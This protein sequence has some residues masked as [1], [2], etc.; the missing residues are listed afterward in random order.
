MLCFT[1]IYFSL[2]LGEILLVSGRLYG[3]LGFLPGALYTMMKVPLLHRGHLNGAHNDV[4]IQSRWLAGVK[5]TNDKRQEPP[6]NGVLLLGP[7]SSSIGPILPLYKWPTRSHCYSPLL[8]SVMTMTRLYVPGPHSPS[9]RQ[10]AFPSRS[11]I[12]LFST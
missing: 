12:L 5:V 10:A 8:C 7:L 11:L 6:M 9:L 4:L 3:A 2:F 1:N